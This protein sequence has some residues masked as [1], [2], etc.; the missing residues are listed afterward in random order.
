MTKTEMTKTGTARRKMTKSERK[1]SKTFG[2]V[3]AVLMIYP[4]VVLFYLYANAST[5]GLG[6]AELLQS[7]PII[8]VTFITAM[9]QPFAAWLLTIVQRRVE[10]AD[11]DSAVVTV[12]LIFVAEALM[13]NVMGMVGLGVLFWFMYKDM[14]FTFRACFKE[15]DKGL[16]MKD[17][18]GALVLIAL[19]AICMF[20]MTRIGL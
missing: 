9:L 4:F 7:D 10:S 20:A 12:L 2:I 6:F 19:G 8:T 18:T 17:A 1:L 15:A 11:Y 5:A 14:P 13:E 16:I 3:K